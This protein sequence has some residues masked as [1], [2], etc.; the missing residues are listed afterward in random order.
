MVR[1]EKVSDTVNNWPKLI[2]VKQYANWK[3]KFKA[4]VQSEDA[5][6]WSCMIDGYIA[7]TRHVNQE[8]VHNYTKEEI[9]KMCG[10]D[11]ETFEFDFEEELVNIEIDKR[12]E[13][14]FTSILDV[15]DYDEVIVEDD[16]DE[17]PARHSSQ[18]TDNFPRF[19][20]MFAHEADDIVLR[21]IEER[22]KDGESPR[23]SQDE[24]KDVRKKWFKFLPSERKFRKPFAFFTRIQ[25][26]YVGD[27]IS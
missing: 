19:S 14:E 23:L 17:E 6:M 12:D 11:E 15:N 20:E 24:I 8:F 3:K 2:T 22:I 1:M 4:F 25:D 5:R 9:V 13:Y 26:I 21:K 10:V 7:P 16:S 18:Y 27:I